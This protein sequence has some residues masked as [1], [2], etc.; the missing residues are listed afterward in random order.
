MDRAPED[1]REIEEDRREIGPDSNRKR[2]LL[3]EPGTS[4][5]RRK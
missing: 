3:K 4:F 2:T 1:T 5:K